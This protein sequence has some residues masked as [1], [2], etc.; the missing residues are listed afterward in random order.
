M[1]VIDL[2]GA[3]EFGGRR[4]FAEDALI[5]FVEE[6][7]RLGT[8]LGIPIPQLTAQVSGLQVALGLTRE[9]LSSYLDTVNVLDNQTP[10]FAKDIIEIVSQQGALAQRVGVTKEG[11]AALGTTLLATNVT[12]EEAFTAI[13]NVLSRLAQGEAAPKQMQEA[14]ERLGFTVADFAEI[15][16]QEGVGAFGLLFDQ[17]EKMDPVDAN[18]LILDVFEMRAGSTVAK[19]LAEGPRQVLNQALGIVADEAGNRGSVLDEFN[20]KLRTTRNQL[21]L[22]QNEMVD[23]GTTSGNVLLPGIVEGSKGIGGMFRQ[24]GMLAEQYPEYDTDN[25]RKHGCPC[26]VQCR[27]GGGPVRH[28]HARSDS[29]RGHIRVPVLGQGANVCGAAT[30]RHSGTVHQ[31]CVQHRCVCWQVGADR[32]SVGVLRGGGGYRCICHGRRMDLQQLE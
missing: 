12:A 31:G 4:G 13:R 28:R 11:L 18:A 20:I 27:G 3:A 29:E 1:P 17:L 9:E 6:T 26:R 15:L 23:F 5:P 30:V 25:C 16:H 32:P 19:L 24:L 2:V 8:A 21:T 10:A 14:F 7:A 22:A